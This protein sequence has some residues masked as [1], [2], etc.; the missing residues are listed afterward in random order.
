MH[1]KQLNR[2]YKFR[3]VYEII[4]QLLLFEAYYIEFEHI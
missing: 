1:S 4:L 2:I 3:I